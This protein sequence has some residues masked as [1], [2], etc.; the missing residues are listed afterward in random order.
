MDSE[1]YCGL[2]QNQWDILAEQAEE[3]LRDQEYGQHIL[4]LYPA[5]PRIYGIESSSPSLLCLYVDA[6]DSLI[7]PSKAYRRQLIQE[8]VGNS[9]SKIYFIELYEWGKWLF[10]TLTT[11]GS[12]VLL[13]LLPTMQDIFYEDESISNITSI[14]KE[15][16]FSAPTPWPSTGLYREFP[17][18][19]MRTLTILKFRQTFNPCVNK[20][21][22]VVIGLDELG[23]DMPDFILDLD[24]KIIEASLQPSFRLDIKVEEQ[25]IRYLHAVCSN[26]N[27]SHDNV[28]KYNK[29][30]GKEIA[31][32]Y[33]YQL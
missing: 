25:Y 23:L 32:L 20:E 31:N 11:S 26:E 9:N 10:D 15:T 28:I 13:P 5:G 18:L 22:G 27:Q 1:Y 29:L 12:Q 2:P 6:V 7:D 3:I 4:G 8:S 17:A 33:R 19:Q 14:A 24:K 21:L 16:V 30:L